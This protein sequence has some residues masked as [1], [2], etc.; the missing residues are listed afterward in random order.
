MTANAVT[1]H[2]VQL[3]TRGGSAITSMATNLTQNTGGVFEVI[4]ASSGLDDALTNLASRMNAH[5]ERV[6]NWYRVLYERP[7]PPGTRLTAGV[8]ARPGILFNLFIDRRML[9]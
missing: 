9:Q 4:N 5:Y 6:S 8:T 2:A 3:S 7:D 1:I